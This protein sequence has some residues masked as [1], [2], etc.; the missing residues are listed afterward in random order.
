MLIPQVASVKF[1]PSSSK[2]CRD[3]SYDE[4]RHTCDMDNS[5]GGGLIDVVVRVHKKGVV[6]LHRWCAVAG[7]DVQL[8]KVRDE[9]RSRSL[10]SPFMDRGIE[11]DGAEFTGG[12][13]GG[14]VE[15]SGDRIRLSRSVSLATEMAPTKI[16]PGPHTGAV[17]PGGREPLAAVEGDPLP[18]HVHELSA[19]HAFGASRHGAAAHGQL[20]GFTGGIAEVGEDRQQAL[21][22]ITA[23][24]GRHCAGKRLDS[25]LLGDQCSLPSSPDNFQRW[26]DFR[27]V[28]DCGVR[29]VRLPLRHAGLIRPA[30]SDH[31]ASNSTS[32]RHMTSRAFAVDHCAPRKPVQVCRVNCG[33]DF[34]SGTGSAVTTSRP[35]CSRMFSR[36]PAFQPSAAVMLGRR[37]G[38]EAVLSDA[39]RRVPEARRLSEPG[40]CACGRTCRAR[41]PR[42]DTFRALRRSAVPG[43]PAS[44]DVTSAG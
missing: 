21:P 43:V 32:Q 13:S 42:C 10:S 14:L 29:K 18:L 33:D 16:R 36:V 24:S 20:D 40:N 17:T 38:G 4:V 35:S 41:G 15:A 9:S 27:A 7:F 1:D 37:S 2:W 6:L 3:G 11:P 12:G 22:R 19:V 23:Q 31:Q 5:R 34:S 39:S 44:R 26:G 30:T 25:E 8:M 28:C